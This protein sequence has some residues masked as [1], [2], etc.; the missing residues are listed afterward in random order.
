MRRKLLWLAVCMLLV[1]SVV[2]FGS[3]TR[4]RAFSIDMADSTGGAAQAIADETPTV[5]PGETP[6]VN[7]EAT[8]D[9]TQET[10]TATSEQTPTATPA[11][12][13]TPEAT[14]TEDPNKPATSPC[15]KIGEVV[16][17]GEDWDITLNSVVRHDQMASLKPADGK[18]FLVA[19][20]TMK[21]IS[22]KNE[23]VSQLSQYTLES[24]SGE[25]Y[26]LS[27]VVTSNVQGDVKPGDDLK[28]HLVYEVPADQKDYVLQY[29]ENSGQVAPTRWP[30][31]F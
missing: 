23:T 26:P 12:T 8:P 18:R 3:S 15:T 6:T 16:K 5:S 7:P 9:A 25:K 22:S 13:P 30:L 11:E 1:G 27:Q 28:G 17:I 20:V 2:V 31:A 10:P 19:D 21:N 24:S 29:Q 4:T 14:P